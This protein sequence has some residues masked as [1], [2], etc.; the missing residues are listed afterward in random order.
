[1][2]KRSWAISSG[3]HR[4]GAADMDI[5]TRAKEVISALTAEYGPGQSHGIAVMLAIA[6]SRGEFGK[7]AW[8]GWFFKPSDKAFSKAV[9][10]GLARKTPRKE[11]WTLTTLGRVVQPNY[12]DGSN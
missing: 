3:P 10:M 5:H 1:M 4:L 12:K 7:D 11:L 8:D 6:P 2:A 9:R